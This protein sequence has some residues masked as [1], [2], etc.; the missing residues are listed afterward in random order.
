MK[1]VVL[2]CSGQNTWDLENRYSGWTDIDLCDAGVK[3]A[4]IAGMHLKHAG[5]Q[6]DLAFTSV[7]TRAIHT[8]WLVQD[9]M[10]NKWMPVE[11]DWRLNPRNIGALQGL[12]KSE[13]R[14]AFGAENLYQW[15]RTY[16]ALPPDLESTD[17]RHPKFDFRYEQIKPD[18]LPACESMKETAIRVS[19][20]W[21]YAIAPWV[22]QGKRVLLVAHETTL[23]VL[24]QHFENLPDEYVADLHIPKGIPL[25]YEFDDD[26]AVVDHYY[27]DEFQSTETAEYTSAAA[28]PVQLFKKAI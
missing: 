18:V 15:F 11:K 9:V 16:S 21:E 5:Y 8:L 26:F 1:K 2:I 10:Q 17:L 28:D 25:V 23:K 24:I 22:Q 13:A 6:F 7:L 3:Q 19:K 27:V 14:V 4:R 12:T 20:Y